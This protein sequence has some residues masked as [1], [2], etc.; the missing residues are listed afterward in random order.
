M[1]EDAGEVDSWVLFTRQVE[2]G[3]DVA[4]SDVFVES[5]DGGGLVVGEDLLGGAFVVG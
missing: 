1:V 4:R 3:V 2:V 5:G